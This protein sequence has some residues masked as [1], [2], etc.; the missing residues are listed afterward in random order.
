MASVRKG[1]PWT[2][3]AQRGKT[4]K[5]DCKPGPVL[6]GLVGLLSSLFLFAAPALAQTPPKAPEAEICKGCHADYVE[7]YFKTKHGQHGNVAGATC[8][9]CHGQQA[10]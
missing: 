4:M 1:P 6:S 3:D 10:P 9:S 8:V 5:A 2:G 7:S